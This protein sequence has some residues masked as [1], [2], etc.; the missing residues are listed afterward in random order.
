MSAKTTQQQAISGYKKKGVDFVA[1]EN[2]MN[3]K[4]IPPSAIMPEARFVR[5]GLGEVILKQEAGWTYIKD[6]F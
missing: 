4:S 5:M 1:C 3:E 6:G 2:T